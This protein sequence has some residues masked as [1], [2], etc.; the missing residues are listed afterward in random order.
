V[1]AVILICS[2]IV[3]DL[4]AAIVK[5][6]SVSC[7][8]GSIDLFRYCWIHLQ[9]A[10]TKEGSVSRQSRIYLFRYLWIHLQTAGVKGVVSAV[11]LE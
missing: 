10:I 1:S 3:G 7:N 4:R 5:E 11:N 9:S 6:D 2:D 8:L